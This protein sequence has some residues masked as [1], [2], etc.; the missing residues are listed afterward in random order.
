MDM[1]PFK[2]SKVFT[3]GVELEYQIVNPKSLNLV[4]QAKDFI[5]SVKDTPY[6]KNIKPE[7]TQSMLEINSSVHSS[8]DAL[9]KEL[10]EIR[11]FLILEAQQFNVLFC[12]GG[13]HPF[14]RWIKRKVFPSA[15]FRKLYRK[16]KYLSKRATV[17]GMHIHVSCPN[18]EDALY[19]THLLGRFI[20][21]FIAISAASPFL[22]GIDTGFESARLTIYNASSFFGTTPY[23]V[24]WKEFSAY[25]YKMKNLG[26]IQSM[27]DFHWDIRPQP[28]F[29]TVETRIC[30]CPLTLHQARLIATYVQTLAHHLMHEKPW[31]VNED[32]YLLYNHNRFQATRYGFAG[33]FINPHT[34]IKT[35]IYDD[36]IETLELIM[37]TAKLLGNA[38]WIKELEDNVIQKK[39]DTSL[40]RELYDQTGNFKEVVQQQ[41]SLWTL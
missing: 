11:N 3:L 15:R 21:H 1:L 13:T 35:K 23:L 40:L 28:E 41:C 17:F 39:N 38:K 22:Q 33:D 24:N 27:K 18:A 8:S 20:P 5:R 6:E 31:P 26:I 2:E 19:L 7:I 14:Q 36:L 12:G 30:D 34:L 32:I 16:Y 29:G 4:S 37:P 9:W 10:T 25:Y